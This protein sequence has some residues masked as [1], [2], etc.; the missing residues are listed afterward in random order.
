[1]RNKREQMEREAQ[2][3][4]QEEERKTQAIENEKKLVELFNELNAQLTSETHEEKPSSPPP[5]PL[6]AENLEQKDPDDGLKQT[7]TSTTT[8][9]TNNNITTSEDD[10]E[11]VDVIT[12]DDEL[13]K[14]IL[15]RTTPSLYSPIK[16]NNEDLI[17]YFNL[18]DKSHEDKA[19]RPSSNANINAETLSR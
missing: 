4:K 6:S 10:D 19:N 2:H 17:N 5:P 1:M 16:P 14:K 13:L 7:T 18:V 9:T 15:S 11:C 8:T 3:T 12:D